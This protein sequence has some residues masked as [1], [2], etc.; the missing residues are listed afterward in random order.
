MGGLGNHPRKGNVGQVVLVPSSSDVA[1]RATASSKELEP[2]ENG[3]QPCRATA[4]EPNLLKLL[5]FG[6]PGLGLGPLRGR[7]VLASL[8]ESEGVQGELD[9]STETL[10]TGRRGVNWRQGER[11][12]RKAHGVAEAE[13]RSR[14]RVRLV[15]LGREAHRSHSVENSDSPA[16]H[17]VSERASVRTSAAPKTKITRT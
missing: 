8:V 14:P 13:E 15:N 17:L 16:P 5:A 10:K 9:V 6:P 12:K 7:K 2:V 1:V 3:V 11:R 4:P